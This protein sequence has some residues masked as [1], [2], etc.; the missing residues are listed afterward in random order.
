MTG[1]RIICGEAVGELLFLLGT[2]ALVV[3][4]AVSSV[5]DHRF[6]PV[7]FFTA[8]GASVESPAFE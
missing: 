1:L 7:K 2:I 6:A 4:D 5:A 3:P 8:L